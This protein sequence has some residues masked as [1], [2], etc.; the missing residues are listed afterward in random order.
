MLSP[1]PSSPLT[2]SPV[3]FQWSAGSSVAEYHLYVGTTPGGKDIYNL[4]QGTGT[5]VSVSGIPINGNPVYARLWWRIGGTWSSTDYTYQTQGDPA[6][7][8]PTPGSPLTA[9][10]VTVQWSAGSGVA[11]YH[12]YVGT[13]PGGKD[14]YTQSQGT[15]TSVSVSGIPLNGN[16]AYA[17]L[18]WRIGATWFWADYTYQT[19]EVE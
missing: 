10:P 5:S 1:P 11:E 12:L 8:S 3:T 19:Q 6:L 4:S 2:A 14:I 7:T 17:R 9:S 13:T 18:W 15:G 16:P